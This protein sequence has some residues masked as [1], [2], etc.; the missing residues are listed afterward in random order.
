MQIVSRIMKTAKERPF[1]SKKWQSPQ[2]VEQVDFL[3]GVT[4]NHCLGF[5]VTHYQK[6]VEKR[7]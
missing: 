2:C 7:E 4:Q 3:K 5:L 1:L 6:Q